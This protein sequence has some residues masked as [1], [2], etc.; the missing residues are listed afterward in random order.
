MSIGERK[1][2]RKKEIEKENSTIAILPLHA[3]TVNL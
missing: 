3:I 2:G 1:K